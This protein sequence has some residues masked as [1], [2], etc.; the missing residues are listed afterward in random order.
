VGAEKPS[1]PH[2]AIET[3]E[4][5]PVMAAHPEP[6]G[7]DVA[8]PAPSSIVIS[9][10]GVRPSAD[11]VA[12]GISELG[13][14]AANVLRSN[15]PLKAPTPVVI[16]DELKV[17]RLEIKRDKGWAYLQIHSHVRIGN[18]A[19]DFKQRNEKIRWELRR[20]ENRWVSSAPAERTFVPRDAAVR[21]LAAQ[22]AE[23]TQSEA[24]A[25]HD[26]TVV[27]QEA[28]IASLLSALLEK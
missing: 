8:E 19:A 11:E 16:F 9:T 4:R 15:E 1:R 23:M 18:E 12:D 24:A 17:E 7:K 10:K 27:A 20:E 6:L 14:A 21:V 26:E 5:T 3:S 22:L 2:A 13:N 25:Q 28:H